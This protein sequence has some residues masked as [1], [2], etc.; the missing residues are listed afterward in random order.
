MLRRRNER[1]GACDALTVDL[2]R[3]LLALNLHAHRFPMARRDRQRGVAKGR[4]GVRTLVIVVVLLR[5]EPVVSDAHAA[6]VLRL[7][8]LDAELHHAR[9][10]EPHLELKDRVLKGQYAHGLRAALVGRKRGAPHR[11]VHELPFAGEE[12]PA[13]VGLAHGTFLDD[14][15]RRP[16]Q[17]FAQDKPV[18][19]LERSAL[20]RILGTDIEAQAGE[21]QQKEC[22]DMVERLPHGQ[23]MKQNAAGPSLLVLKT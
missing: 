9:T 10:V 13:A 1:V 22:G 12:L 15:L 21:N 23:V 17:V 6:D 11:A 14:L 4:G 7:L 5:G 16:V 18:K 2:S 19:F 8:V 20:G 3:H